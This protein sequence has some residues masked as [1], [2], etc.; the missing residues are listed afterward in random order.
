LNISA[1]CSALVDIVWHPMDIQCKN[2]FDVFNPVLGALNI[3][4]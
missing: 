2:E 1:A 3:K 4:I